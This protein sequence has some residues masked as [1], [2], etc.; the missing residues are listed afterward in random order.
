[1]KRHA[2]LLSGD[3]QAGVVCSKHAHHMLSNITTTPLYSQFQSLPREYRLVTT[4]AYQ[5]LV[6]L[7]RSLFDAMVTGGSTE[8][9]ANIPDGHLTDMYPAYENIKR[10]PVPQ[11]T[12][13]N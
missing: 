12:L 10:I 2:T 1:M 3:A 9:S 8:Y 5:T 4:S 7:S 11:L 13:N 6:E